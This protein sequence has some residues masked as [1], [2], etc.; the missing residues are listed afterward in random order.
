MSRRE[1][2]DQYEERCYKRTRYKKN[3][4]GG[5]KKVVEGRIGNSNPA[6]SSNALLVTGK[7]TLKVQQEQK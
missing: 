1:K 2:F 3:G 4:D 5:Y 7:N 6:K